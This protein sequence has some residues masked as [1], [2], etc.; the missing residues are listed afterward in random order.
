[1]PCTEVCAFPLQPCSDPC[2]PS[3]DSE[4]VFAEAG[5]MVLKVP[6]MQEMM[7][8]TFIENSTMLQLLVDKP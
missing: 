5:K 4:K 1:M 8:G 2:N 3:H 7:Y 6:G